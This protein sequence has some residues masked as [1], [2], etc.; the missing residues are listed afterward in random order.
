[1]KKSDLI[2]E[3]FSLQIAISS[4]V[5]KMLGQGVSNRYQGKPIKYSLVLTLKE[6]DDKAIAGN[7]LYDELIALNTLEIMG[8]AEL[9]LEL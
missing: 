2:A 8:E 7:S 5:H 4:T 9:T 6:H 1:M 3:D